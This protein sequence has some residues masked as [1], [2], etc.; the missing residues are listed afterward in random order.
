[1]SK[2]LINFA[3]VFLDKKVGQ[4]P[5]FVKLYKMDL[6]ELSLYLKHEIA[7][8]PL[9]NLEKIENYDYHQEQA[10]LLWD[11]RNCEV[12]KVFFPTLTMKPEYLQCE[13]DFFAKQRKRLRF[14]ENILSSREN[15]LQKVG[16]YLCQY[17]WKF[18]QESF[19]FS[20]LSVEKMSFD[21]QISKNICY[22]LLKNKQIK[23]ADQ[24]KFL[25]EFLVKG[26]GELSLVAIKRKVKAMV[27]SGENDRQIAEK[28]QAS[29]VKISRRTV[30]KYRRQ[31]S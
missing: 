8:N 6:R 1:M 27:D 7:S 23:F 14:L 25:S 17:Q 31:L 5:L 15:L 19:S 26:Q 3:D 13:G 29:G 4:S 18:W 9:L 24:S 30:C 20:P 10:D 12:N 11:G 2:S 21:L 22:A 28:L 16:Q